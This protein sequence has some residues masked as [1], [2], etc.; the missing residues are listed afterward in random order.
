MKREMLRSYRVGLWLKPSRMF[1]TIVI[2]SRQRTIVSEHHLSK[3]FFLDLG[4]KLVNKEEEEYYNYKY[5][6]FIYSKEHEPY[7]NAIFVGAHPIQ[8]VRRFL[9]DRA[10][11]TLHDNKTSDCDEKRS[12]Y[13]EG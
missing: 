5:P 1:M 3:D 9:E 10:K 11:G 8:I 7:I 4:L 2:D 6:T 12:Q 13:A